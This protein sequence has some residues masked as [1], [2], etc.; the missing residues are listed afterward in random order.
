MS[1][2]LLRVCVFCRLFSTVFFLPFSFLFLVYC[3]RTIANGCD[4]NQR[5]KQTKHAS[6]TRTRTHTQKM[7]SNKLLTEKRMSHHLYMNVWKC[8]FYIFMG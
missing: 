7:G 4:I 1:D 6:N 8:T 3:H 2:S 5:N